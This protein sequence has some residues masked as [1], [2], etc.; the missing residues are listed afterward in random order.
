MQEALSNSAAAAVAPDSV[1]R[2]FRN[3]QDSS[4][5]SSFKCSPS[6]S[7]SHGASSHTLMPLPK[8]GATDFIDQFGVRS[9]PRSPVG[10]SQNSPSRRQSSPNSRPLHLQERKPS[11]DL[12]T[13]SLKPEGTPCV[14]PVFSVDNR[15]ASTSIPKMVAQSQISMGIVDALH[16]DAS[17]EETDELYLADGKKSPTGLGL[18]SKGRAC[19]TPKICSPMPQLP[20]HEK[21][22][23]TRQFSV[24]RREA[25]EKFE[26][27]V[28]PEFNKFGLWRKDHL[29][30][31]EFVREIDDGETGS[32]LFED[33]PG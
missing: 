6:L 29:D 14:S 18:G 5:K 11:H 20:I 31:G 26:R 17:C 1:H 32:R 33:L 15:R 21:P 24:S 25:D 16:L 30:K 22:G 7:S 10:R 28:Q 3:F 9:P 23:V 8:L 4:F 13:P 27:Q 19:R 2:S 12:R